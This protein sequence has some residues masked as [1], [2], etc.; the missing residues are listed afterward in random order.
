[1][2][3]GYSILAMIRDALPNGGK[4]CIQ[5]SNVRVDEG[6]APAGA[7]ILP[8][9]FVLLEVTDTGV[10]MDQRTQAHIFE[11]FFTTKAL[12]KGTRKAKSRR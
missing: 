10:G 7:G 9:R 3:S 1:M 2:G 4:L 8:G 6:S 12:G 5:T 11:P